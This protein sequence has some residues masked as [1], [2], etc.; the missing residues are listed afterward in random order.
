MGLIYFFRHAQA[1][2]RDNYDILS[3]L[4]KKQA[5]LL[6]K[7]LATEDI[8]F[9]AVYCGG[10]LRQRLSAEI[11]CSALSWSGLAVPEIQTDERWN[12][13]S[14]A[15][16]YAWAAPRMLESNQEF[17][18]DFKEMQEALRQDPH[19]TS[20]ATGRCDRAVIKAWIRKEYDGFEGESWAAFSGRIGACSSELFARN[21]KEAVA[22]FT[23]ATPIVIMTGAALGLADEK[24]LS[25][26]GVL[27]NSS[28]TIMRVQEGDL[29]LFS[30]NGVSYLPVGL[31]TY[32]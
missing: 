2:A 15:S 29:R 3:E 17:A 20:G 1:G 30:F 4:G 19:T 25:L 32:R 14:L 11:A 26:A 21:H 6:G 28:I 8:R 5:R 24:L 18:A 12:E 23:S 9:S 7:F 10:M 16:V 27:Q 13:F 31:R 22:V